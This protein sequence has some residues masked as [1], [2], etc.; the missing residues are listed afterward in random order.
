M[1]CYGEANHRQRNFSNYFRPAYFNW[2]RGR[3]MTARTIHYFGTS[4]PFNLHARPLKKWF[5]CRHDSRLCFLLDTFS[6]GN[7]GHFR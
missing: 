6:G 3:Y 1:R 7:T 5:P 4:I 2:T